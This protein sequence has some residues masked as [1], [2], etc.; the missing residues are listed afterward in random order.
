MGAKY[1]NVQ[2]GLLQGTF[3]NDY[4][5]SVDHVADDGP[6]RIDHAVGDKDTEVIQ[7]FREL[8]DAVGV[9][10]FEDDRVSGET[11]QAGPNLN[12]LVVAAGNEA[13]P[14]FGSDR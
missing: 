9:V 6:S 14:R 11:E 13:V 5:P 1:I 3:T 2:P 10:D 7:D 12:A 8:Q 4:E